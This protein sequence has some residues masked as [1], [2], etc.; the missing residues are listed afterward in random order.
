MSTP[1]EENRYRRLP[2]PVHPEDLV[3]TVDVGE[4]GPGESESEQRDRMLREAGGA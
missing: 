1:A 2:E 4:H 3:E